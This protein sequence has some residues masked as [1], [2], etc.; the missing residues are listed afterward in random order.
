MMDCIYSEELMM[1][2]CFYLEVLV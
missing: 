2:I 1:C